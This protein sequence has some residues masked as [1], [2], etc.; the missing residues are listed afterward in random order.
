MK[1]IDLDLDGV[2]ILEPKKNVDHRGFYM[3]SYSARTLEGFGIK[4]IFLQDNHSKTLNKGTLR[5]IHFQNNPKP[6]TKLVRCIKGRILD[7]VIDLKYNSLTYKKWIAIELSEENNKQ[8]LIPNGYGH[9]F[10]T[11]TDN[12]EVLYKV[13]QF[14]EPQYDRAIFWNDFDIGINLGIYNPILSRKDLN[15]PFLKNSDCNLNIEMND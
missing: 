6:Q 15:A 10:Y 12:C 11:L 7:L 8:I 13:D 9:A 4:T 14:Y 5:G 3:E 1:I 2:K